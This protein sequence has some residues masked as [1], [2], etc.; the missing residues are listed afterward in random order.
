[1]E[2]SS[3][4]TKA[5]LTIITIKIVRAVGTSNSSINSINSI[6]KWSATQVQETSITLTN[7]GLHITTQAIVDTSQA[8]TQFYSIRFSM[9]ITN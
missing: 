9:Q 7:K 6:S 8:L 2:L 1:M 4:R 5:F 3:I